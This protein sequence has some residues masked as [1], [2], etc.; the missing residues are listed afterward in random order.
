MMQEKGL[1]L[2]ATND[3]MSVV[4]TRMF[5]IELSR[6]KNIAKTRKTIYHVICQQ[7]LDTNSLIYLTS[8]ECIDKTESWVFHMDHGISTLG[9][10]I[11]GINTHNLLYEMI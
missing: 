11:G 5:F 1:I 9:P 4:D 8:I 3:V 10:C 6:K 7:H 2:L